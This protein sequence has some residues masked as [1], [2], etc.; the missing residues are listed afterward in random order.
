MSKSTISTFE[1]FQMFPDQESARAYFEER[2]WPDGATCPACGEAERIGTRKGGFYRCNACLLDFTVR[3]G[4][5]FERSK[6][7]LHKWLYAM[8]LLVTARKGISSV[9][10]HAQIGVTQKTA[11]FMLQRLREAC[12]NDPTELAGT[13]EID[14]CYIGGKESA[15]HESKRL[16][17]G[18]GGVGK[19]AVIAGRERESGQVKA[20]VRDT[21]TGRNANGFTSRHV[22]VGSTIHTDESAIYNRVGGLLYKHE[23]INH[24]AGEYVRGDVTTNGIES[25]FALLKRGLHG[26]YHHASPKHLHRYVGEFAF[27]LGD[28][29]VSHHTM[30]RLE[31]LF[32]AAIGRR[33]T[34]AELIA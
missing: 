22:Q 20:E 32:S 14:E 6:V 30:Q 31:R 5:I 33:I 3:T 17:L 16:K 19:T 26:V 4:T 34:Y 21:V 12:G 7:P 25:V 29:D 15:K 28:G 27:R 8:Y 9:Q 23:R 1:L 24:S 10:L 11:W 18:R 2:R 13:V